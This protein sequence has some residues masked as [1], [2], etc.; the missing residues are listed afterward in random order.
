MRTR[1]LA[2]AVL[3]LAAGRLSAATYTVTNAA[4][5]GAGSLRQAILDANAN[6]GA[7][8]IVFNIPGSGL[9]TIVLASWLPN[10]TDPVTV[11]GYTQPGSIPNTLPLAQGTNAALNIEIDG[12]ANT[13]APCWS[14]QAN[15]GLIRGLVI[16]RC[17]DG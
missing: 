12:A 2:L 6:P 4:D 13:L 1:L 10:A 15:G 17:P 11:D 14:Y 16:N 5:S 8:T 9:H 3:L 7:D